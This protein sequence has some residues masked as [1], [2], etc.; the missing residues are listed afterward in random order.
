VH[1]PARP[2]IL[3]ELAGTLPLWRLRNVIGPFRIASVNVAR[4]SNWQVGAKTV[5]LRFCRADCSVGWSPIDPRETSLHCSKEPSFDHVVR[6]GEQFGWHG[7]AKHFRRF[8]IDQQFNFSTLLDRKL[9]R[10]GAL[11]NFSDIDPCLLI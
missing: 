3:A 4:V 2:P 6:T 5:S 1:R 8:K 10:L 7:D 11:E 9:S